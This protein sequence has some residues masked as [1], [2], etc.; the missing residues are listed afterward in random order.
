[1]IVSIKHPVM[2]GAA[3][4]FR[5]PWNASMSFEEYPVD[6]LKEGERKWISWRSTMTGLAIH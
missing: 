2:R 4:K 3:R 6:A 1:M 5:T